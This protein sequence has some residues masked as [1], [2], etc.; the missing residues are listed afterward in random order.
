MIRDWATLERDRK[1]LACERER[2][3]SRACRFG[4]TSFSSMMWANSGGPGVLD[5][6]TWTPTSW[7]RVAYA[8][9]NWTGEASA[10]SIVASP[11][12]SPAVGAALNGFNTADFN[13]TTH[14]LNATLST[15]PF[16][17]GASTAGTAWALFN[18]DTATAD[19][20]AYYNNPVIIGDTSGSAHWALAFSTAG[21]IAGA[22][23]GGGYRRAATACGT[24]GW[25]LGMARF[26][27][28]AGVQV[29]VDSGAWTAFSPNTAGMTFGGGTGFRIGGNYTAGILFDG[30]IADVGTDDVIRS[31]GECD[32]LKTYINTR[33]GLAL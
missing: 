13:G 12:T 22:L 21:F 24:S 32:Q 30:R 17:T 8:G 5:P 28:A 18:A 1:T 23:L 2:I 15:A 9:P 29:R 31:D 16:V 6:A 26:S 3:R 25:H 10:G 27:V 19:A 20:A 7:W 11:G 4:A 14:H 33:Y